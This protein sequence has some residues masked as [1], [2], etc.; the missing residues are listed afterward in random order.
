VLLKKFRLLTKEEE[1]E[2]FNRWKKEGDQQAYDLLIESMLR[3]AT[4]LAKRRL[5]K[6]D[7][8]GD[9]NLLDEL[10]SCAWNSVLR[11][12]NIFDPSR[13]RLITL[14]N[15]TVLTDFNRRDQGGSIA[16]PRNFTGVKGNPDNLA[17]YERAKVQYS[18]DG[19]YSDTGCSEDEASSDRYHPRIEYNLDA[20]LELEEGVRF[21]NDLGDLNDTQK[22]ILHQ[23]FYAEKTLKEI[24]QV[25]DLTR[26]RIRQIEAQA[27]RRL[28]KRFGI[29]SSKKQYTLKLEQS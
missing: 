20:A 1:L 2:A 7:R 27:I 22:Y 12:V 28:R 14:V 24:A 4:M 25:L 16:L 9:L 13:A 5:N 6:M 11:A 10:E 21:I 26:E 29:K 8:S 23:R 19:V 3:Y 18:V 15:W 17:A